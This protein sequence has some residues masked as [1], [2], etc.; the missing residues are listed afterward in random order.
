MH[1]NLEFD[2]LRA[3]YEA[4]KEIGVNV[5]IYLSAGFD[6]LMGAEHPEW[7]QISV[8]G[9]YYG[10]KAVTEPGFMF[11]CFNSP[12]LDYLCDQ[13]SEVAGLFPE[14]DGIF[15]DII[16]QNQCCCRHCLKYMVENRLNP[17]SE[18]DR[19]SCAEAA[20]LRYY[21]E[22]TAASRQGRSDMPVFHNSGHVAK[23]EREKLKYF[24]HLE[25]E[26]LPTGGW[27]YDHFPLSA[28]YAAKL[29][30]GFLGMTGKFHTT[31]GEF[32]G[33][34]HPNALRYECASMTANGAKCSIGDQLHPSGLMDESTYRIIGAAYS[35]VE[36]RQSWCEKAVP[37]ADIAVL[38]SEAESQVSDADM[39]A[40]RAL[41]EGHF[42]FDLIDREMDLFG[43]KLLILPDEIRIDTDLKRRIDEYLAVGGRLL[44]TGK[45][46]LWKDGSGFAFDTGCEWFGE[47]DSQ[48][49]YLEPCNILAPDFVASPMVMYMGS[50]QVR[51]ISG[52][53]LAE[54][55]L[56]YFN[57]TW[58]HFCGHQ[59]APAGEMS[60]Y[61]G[62]VRQGNIMYL[63]H[64][65]FS[66]YRALGAVAY[67]E[68]V[69]KVISMML[70]A[71]RSVTTNLPSTARITLMNQP[72]EDRLILHLCYANMSHRG[73]E[74]KLSPE[75]FVMN[76]HPVEVIEDLPMLV[77][78]ELSIKTMRKIRRAVLQPQGRELET[79]EQ[80]G[81]ICMTVDR[82][83]CHA[84]VVMD[85]SIED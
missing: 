5:P 67:R 24:S 18:E 62:A 82:F 39:G 77:D 16:L 17:A 79:R 30:M 85:Y 49:D 1:P 44:L 25:L 60:E 46:G 71:D 55:R 20:L 15:L 13:V 56:P 72:E 45:S 69:S 80:D 42:L 33:Y 9:E 3:Q 81:C 53:V 74:A 58:D 41:L 84:M 21:K 68:Y 63:A 78:V 37:V 76:S 2:L 12:Y 75:G 47:S 29:G 61:V 50:Q 8:D 54:I 36:E 83:S 64:P 34:K 14:C 35:E 48:P 23:G 4:S 22:T 6:N 43:Y 32:G 70:G 73:T 52:E 59:H 27:G 11:M 28:K 26:S 57:R 38:S 10:P 31:W 65:V 40:G 51:A 7:R 66:M 19:K